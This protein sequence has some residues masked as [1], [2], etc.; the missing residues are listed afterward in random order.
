MLYP[1]LT[2][3]DRLSIMHYTV[4]KQ[5]TNGLFEVGQNIM[6]SEE[7]IRLVRKIYPETPSESPDA[8]SYRP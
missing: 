6:L 3:Y 1:V 2:D 4:D 5:F 8:S 7:D